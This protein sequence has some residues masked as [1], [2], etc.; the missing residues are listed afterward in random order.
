MT[1]EDAIYNTTTN[2]PQNATGDGE[3]SK[4]KSKNKRGEGETASRR[5]KRKPYRFGAK[6]KRELR[7]GQVDLRQWL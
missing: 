2:A 5:S 6:E 4:S 1:P 7:S 3:V